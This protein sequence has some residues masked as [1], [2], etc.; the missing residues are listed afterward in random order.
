MKQRCPGQDFRSLS[1]RI[2]QCP[3]CGADVE[4][5]SNE[6]RVKCHICGS[7]VYKDKTPSCAEWCASAR[8]CLGERRWKQ[9]GR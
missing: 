7:M 5:F 4:I 6:T 8:E 9:S 1:A 2:N 3:D